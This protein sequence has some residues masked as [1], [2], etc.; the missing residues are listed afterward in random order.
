MVS[1]ENIEVMCGSVFRKTD[2]GVFFELAHVSVREFLEHESLAVI[3]G[4]KR[5][6]IS[7]EKSNEM[8]ASQSLRF[9]QLSNFDV[10]L[11]NQESLVN[12]AQNTLDTY[13]RVYI[14]FHRMA[15]GLSLRLSR[16]VQVDSTSARLVKS[17]F[18]PRKSSC[19]L[20]FA[21][22][23]CFDLIHY[24]VS[25]GLIQRS[26]EISQSELAK[27]F[28]RV[29]FQPTHLAAALNLPEVCQHLIDA[30]SNLEADSPLAT[31]LE[32]SVISF[33][34]LILDDGDTQ[35][36]EKHHRHLHSPIRTLLGSN[37]Q[38]NATFKIFEQTELQQLALDSTGRPGDTRLVAH[39]LI[40]AFAENNFWILQKLL[41]R[42]MTLEDAIYTRIFPNLMSQSLP[43]IRN[44]EQPLLSFLQDIGSKLEAESGWPLEIGRLIW[45]TAIE[46]ELAVTKD[47]TV[48][49]LRIS[50]SKDAL[51][52]RAFATI[53]GCD[54]KG[55]R[56]CTADGRLDLSERH[57][58]PLGPQEEN[59]TLHLTLLHFAVLEDNLQATAYLAQA[60][61]NPKTPSVQI[62]TLTRFLPIHECLSIDVFEVL[63]VHGALA[64]DIE[65]HTGK[66]IWHMF[67]A[68]EPD[69]ETEFFR[70][71]EFF[72]S[73]ARRLPVETAEALLTKSKDRRAPLQLLLVS[74]YP[75]I[76]REDLVERVM[77]L[78]EICQGVVDF[79]SRYEPIFAAAAVFG[80][81]RV[82]R[83]LI[84]VGAGVETVSLGRET[85]LHRISTKS[86][87]ASVGCLKQI[88]PEAVHIRFEGQLPI[89]AY[90]E[91]CVFGQHLID[92][93]VARQ[94]W[95]PESLKSID[96]K[97]TT[98]WEYYCDL[99]TTGK[100]ILNQ[101]STATLWAWLLSSDSAMQVYE[102]GS[103]KSGL[104]L[105]LSR[106]IRLDEIGDLTSSIPTTVLVM[107]STQHTAG[108]RSSRTQK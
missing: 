4:L 33:L 99:N 47:P 26:A 88:I 62:G 34:R 54:M 38:H 59:D 89:Q 23:L 6:Q 64:T 70:P 79:W 20:M 85:P 78:I 51:V 29:E 10:E 84:E 100:G 18:H 45:R 17:L 36:V 61:C 68:T 41:D 97:G 74:T 55:L 31:L 44:N 58:A 1:E 42:G 86:T 48:T 21:S 53:K 37:H 56:E 5:Y 40:I 104:V 80:S 52:S 43:G 101:S 81:E 69:T 73:V 105:F 60:G 50:L 108:I 32:L 57:R 24:F 96:G 76:P 11:P 82:I 77:A 93:T 49:D 94:L 12:A 27:K 16:E 13:G 66:N 8:L 98:L 39:A 14:G 22:S 35:L 28:L 103:S 107:P 30:G 87:S 90:L 65:V 102:H 106:L 2:N 91:R 72:E 3:P 25:F 19:L 63:L 95:T 15:A 46:L 83:R 67:N 75:D 92:D 7:R 71:I 9:I